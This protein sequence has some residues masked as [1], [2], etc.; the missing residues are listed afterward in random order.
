MTYC[1]A[2]ATGHEF[3]TSGVNFWMVLRCACEYGCDLQISKPTSERVDSD[4]FGLVEASGARALA[5]ALSRAIF[6]PNLASTVHKMREEWESRHSY[7]RSGEA[8]PDK[9]DWEAAASYF[10]WVFRNCN[11]L[12]DQGEFRIYV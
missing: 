1:I 7:C 5:N 9:T 6:D 8:D 11:E 3:C 12:C 4:L 2:I 10:R